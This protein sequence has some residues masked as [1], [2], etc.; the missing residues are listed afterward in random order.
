MNL[1]T[2]DGRLI[3]RILASVAQGESDAKS[4]RI[5]RKMQQKAEAGENRGGPR[6]YG[7]QK[8][9]RSI[10]VEAAVIRDL[11]PRYLAG[12]S[13]TSLASW[14]T[15]RSIPSTRGKQWHGQTV[16]TILVNPRIAGINVHLGV[17][18]GKGDWEPIITEE[19]HRRLLAA[20]AKRRNTKERPPRRS[21]VKG[22]IYCALCGEHVVSG[23]VRESQIYVCM[24]RPNTNACGSISITASKV[25]SIVADAVLARL[26]S[27]EFLAAVARQGAPADDVDALTDQLGADRAQLTEL[28]EAY[29][30]KQITIAEWIAARNP[31]QERI[32]D[33]ERRIAQASGSP[34]LASIIRAGTSLR[35][36]WDGLEFERKAAIVRALVDTVSIK[37][38]VRRGRES[39]FLARIDL[40][41]AV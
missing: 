21:L 34:V 9:R 4:A 17:E 3:A 11:V 19:E 8:D 41:W 10:D 40:R 20:Y 38:P 29:A 14:L 24:K 22:L 18:V 16:Q 6:P 7:Y 33:V 28:A 15:E 13:A 25:D 39:D 5:K 31:I 2:A 35:D 36:D 1:A 32:A 27:P 37:R 23:G 12:Q 30:A 26:D